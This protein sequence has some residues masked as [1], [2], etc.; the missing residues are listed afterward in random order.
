M[1]SLEDAFRV[2]ADAGDEEVFV[3]GGAEIYRLALP[4]SDRVYLTRVHAEVMGDAVFPE[5]DIENLRL[6]E[7]VRH[8][9]DAKNDYPFS[10]NVYERA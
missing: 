3:I 8:A 1:A 4:R 10:F 9:A 5:I 6:V 7:S 2:A